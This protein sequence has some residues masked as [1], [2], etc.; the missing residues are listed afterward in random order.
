MPIQVDTDEL[1]NMI[2]A[3]INLLNL[4]SSITKSDEIQKLMK[5]FPAESYSYSNFFSA[6]NKSFVKESRQMT[7]QDFLD[8]YYLNLKEISDELKIHIS[9]GEI[10]EFAFQIYSSKLNKGTCLIT[11]KRI[12]YS[13]KALLSHKEHDFK[14][15]AGEYLDRIALELRS[16]QQ[17][18]TTEF[19]YHVDFFITNQRIIAIK[20]DLYGINYTSAPF[21]PDEKILYTLGSVSQDVIGTLYIFTN[22]KLISLGSALFT[23]KVFEKKDIK[24]LKITE[25]KK[26]LFSLFKSPY[27]LQIEAR[28]ET[29][30]YGFNK[31]NLL[32]VEGINKQWLKSE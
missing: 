9:D 25:R 30:K 2:I 3:D 24:S 14:F 18:K 6:Y 12:I 32:I 15:E 7:D 13:I 31:E 16:E 22:K 5:K 28:N 26:G 20:F 17:D 8:A 1:K 29:I 27:E 11:N 19:K 4:Y 23:F 10:V 21:S